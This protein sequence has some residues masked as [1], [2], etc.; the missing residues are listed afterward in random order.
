MIAALLALGVG[1]ALAFGPTANPAEAIDEAA[2]V[3][4]PLQTFP[5]EI[6]EA[7]IVPR[8]GA[9]PSHCHV[10]AAMDGAR[11]EI[12]MPIAP[13]TGDLLIAREERVADVSRGVAIAWS[14]DAA[15]EHVRKLATLIAVAYYP[16]P[17][18]RVLIQ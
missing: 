15:P 3:G 8:A 6:V 11:I 7:K 12:R 4:L 13:W 2:C 10:V 14:A 9:M 18:T 17:P 1:A 5:A 16:H